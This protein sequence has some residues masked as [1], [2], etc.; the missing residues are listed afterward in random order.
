M[1]TV[2]FLH[3]QPFS[4]VIHLVDG[5]PNSKMSHSAHR[6]LPVQKL[7][8]TEFYQTSWSVKLKHF[9]KFGVCFPGS[10]TDVGLQPLGFPQLHNLTFKIDRSRLSLSG[11]R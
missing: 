11:A 5:V 3:L 2:D 8:S 9:D 10:I 4:S 1:K 7:L 6:T